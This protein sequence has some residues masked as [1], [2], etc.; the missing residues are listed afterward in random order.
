MGN[1][2]NLFEVVVTVYRPWL[3]IHLDYSN[4]FLLSP[5]IL[6]FLS[7]ISF[8]LASDVCERL[9]LHL[10]HAH[11][12]LLVSATLIPDP[13]APPPTTHPTT[14]PPPQASLRCVIEASRPVIRPA[15]LTKEVT[16]VCLLSRLVCLT[17][18]L[19]RL[20]RVSAGLGRA[21]KTREWGVGRA[22][23]NYCT[24]LCNTM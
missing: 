4:F 6:C 13:A 11:S 17:S 12:A 21:P 5:Q 16:A 20:S 1:N 8:L 15:A 24:E 18:R 14:S 2:N 22:R 3:Q 7:L 9:C 10:L 19:S 23:R